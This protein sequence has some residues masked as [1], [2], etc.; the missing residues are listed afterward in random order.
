MQGGSKST[1]GFGQ[2]IGWCSGWELHFFLCSFFP[3]SYGIKISFGLSVFLTSVMK[4]KVPMN[5]RSTSAQFTTC[6]P[7]P[8]LQPKSRSPAH[9]AGPSGVFFVS[10]C[11]HLFWIRQPGVFWEGDEAPRIV[12]PAGCGPPTIKPKLIKSE[13]KWELHTPTCI[14]VAYY[15]HIQKGLHLNIPRLI[16]YSFFFSFLV[17]GLELKFSAGEI[18]SALQSAEILCGRCNQSNYNNRQVFQAAHS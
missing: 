2:L 15:S 9:T 6:H 8:L 3:C 1:C 14:L 16:R 10:V 5:A 13:R 4:R 12:S 7:F 17:L 18:G 11:E